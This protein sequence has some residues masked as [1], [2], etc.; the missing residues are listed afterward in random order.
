MKLTKIQNMLM[1]I[2]IGDAFGAGYEFLE[3]GRETVK[4]KFDF[5]KY[6]LHPKDGSES[7]KLTE[8][9]FLPAGHYTDDTQ[10]SIAISELLLSDKEFNHLNLA[11]S[12]VHC[13]K[14][15]PKRAY[16]Q[17]FREFLEDINSGQE[18]IEKI[19]P[20]STRNGA[21]MRAVPLGIVKDLDKVIE[22]AKISAELTHNTPQGIA[23]SV[24]VAMTS[25]FFFHNPSYSSVFDY[26]EIP[27]REID[28]ESANHFR[29]I[30]SMVE[31]DPYLLFG[32]KW[33]SRG[34]PCNG[35][36][37][38][39]AALYIINNFSENP[40]EALRQAVLLGGDTD[41]T[42]AISLGVIAINNGIKNLP[43]FLFNDLTNHNYGRGYIL[44]LGKNLSSKFE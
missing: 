28:E 8:K 38:A 25:H 7:T 2:A 42:S 37:T 43:G 20:F 21:A 17:R 41:S 13:F 4:T 15:D 31:E 10:M 30:E 36:R 27:C 19:K 16:A 32:D 9:G 33:A 35:M 11:D 12:F 14:R 34:V 1:G 39:A 44:N 29:K 6:D 22:Y 18:F 23:S 3:G 40:K 24:C 5:T 26:I